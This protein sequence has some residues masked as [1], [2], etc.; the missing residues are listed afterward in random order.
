MQIN[1]LPDQFSNN[2][3][4]RRADPYLLGLIKGLMGTFDRAY[5]GLRD[6]PFSMGPAY[7][8]PP[9]AFQ[10]P[11]SLD[12]GLLDINNPELMRMQDQWG[13]EPWRK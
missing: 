11:L 9:G 1:S 12:A 13:R 3:E 7:Q 4:D 8:I 6:H 10:N 5:T 2:T